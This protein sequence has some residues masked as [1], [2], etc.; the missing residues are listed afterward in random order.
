MA[1][2]NYN[3]FM[4]Q[5]SGNNHNSSLVVGEASRRLRQQNLANQ[6][7]PVN[8]NNDFTPAKYLFPNSRDDTPFLVKIPKLP[9]ITLGDVK[10]HLPKKGFYRFYFKTE[11]DKEAVFQEESTNEHMAVPL[12]N[13]TVI[14]QCSEGQF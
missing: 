6:S 7:L 9:P 1:P 5:S 10:K 12:W 4:A 2:S 8:P 3:Q 14:V 11:V 13:G